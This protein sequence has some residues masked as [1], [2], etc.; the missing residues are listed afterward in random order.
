M[1]SIRIQ[2]SLSDP[3]ELGESLKWKPVLGQIVLDANDLSDGR[4]LVTLDQPIEFRGSKYRFAVAAPRHE[5]RSIQELLPSGSVLCSF[6]GITDEQAMSSD[7]TSI[8]R[9]RGGLA[10]IG[11][12]RATT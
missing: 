10:F 5:G 2:I 12:L 3:W 11:E 4:A 1:S 8:D 9:W 7:A 6:I